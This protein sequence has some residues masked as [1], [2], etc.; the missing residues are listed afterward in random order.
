MDENRSASGDRIKVLF[1][2]ANPSSTSKLGLDTEAREL[3]ERIDRGHR[4]IDLQTEWAVRPKDLQRLLLQHRPQIVHF[5]GHGTGPGESQDAADRSIAR[6]SSL[7]GSAELVFES[8]NR[9]AAPVSREALA[10]L[11]KVHREYV[12]CVLLNA[13]YSQLQVDGIAQSINFVIGMA[14]PVKDRTAILFAAGFY[15]A[16]SFG[17]E[18]PDAFEQGRVEVQLHGQEGHDIP[19]LRIRPGADLV[20]AQRGGGTTAPAKPKPPSP[21]LNVLPERFPLERA[22]RRA[23]K[24]NDQLL[25]S[26]LGYFPNI[27]TLY[28]Q[29]NSYEEKITI[30]FNY[31]HAPS[32]LVRIRDMLVRWTEMQD[33]G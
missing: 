20:V 21:S 13:C 16:L 2:A 27:S 10:A 17:C 25:N 15:Q 32:D 5:S 33:E 30:L 31:Y 7:A 9:T 1:L 4:L 11:F 3:Q 22:I 28:N 12:Q 24:K 19:R 26:F 6:P 18:I 8:E 14:E 23:T 29:R